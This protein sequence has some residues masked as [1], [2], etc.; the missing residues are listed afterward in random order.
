MTE[1]GPAPTPTAG[2]PRSGEMRALT[3]DRVAAYLRENPDFLNAHPEL[4]AVLVPP[5]QSE[6]N[7][8]DFQQAM[9][10]RLREEN[11]KLRSAQDYLVTTARNNQSIQ[12]RV[13]D[14]VLAILRASSFE[15]MI[16]T[17]TADLAVLL[18]VDAVTIGVETGDVPIPKAYA[19]GIRALPNGAV[20]SMLGPNRDV[21]LCADINGD[22]RL[23]HSA[24]GLVRS[25]ALCRLRASSQAPVG[26]LAL[27]SRRPDAFQPGQGTELLGFLARALESMIRQ[28]LHLPS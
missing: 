16:Q 8:V 28:W 4:L 18:D 17:V 22:P 27:G 3:A 11:D 10:T 1:K 6:G 25:Q 23:F 5:G 2:K 9:V 7:V 20:D 14:S 21:L 26:L 19:A 12:A 15:T 13:H 24:A